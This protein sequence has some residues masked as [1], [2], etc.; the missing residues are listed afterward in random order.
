MFKWLSRSRESEEKK[1]LLDL[2]RASAEGGRRAKVKEALG[3]RGLTVTQSD[4]TLYCVHAVAGIVFDIAKSAGISTDFE[5]PDERFVAGIFAFVTANHVSLIYS[6]TFEFVSSIA[7][8]E[9]FGKDRAEEV[10]SIGDS[11]NRMSSE[12]R[13]IEAIGNCFAKWIGEPTDNRFED[14]VKLFRLCLDHATNSK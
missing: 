13:V 10:S 9:L 4:D 11:Y 6:A 8:L 7:F 5:D 1:L 12:G 14:L 3:T 2:V